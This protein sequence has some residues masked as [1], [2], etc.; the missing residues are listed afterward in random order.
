MS[1]IVSAESLVAI[2]KHEQYHNLMKKNK[3][4]PALTQKVQILIQGVT[5]VVIVALTCVSAILWSQY[6]NL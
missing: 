6:N 3:K 1:F 4:S 5:I 2:K